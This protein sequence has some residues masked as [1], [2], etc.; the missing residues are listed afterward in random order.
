MTSIEVLLAAGVVVLIAC[1]YGWQ[2]IRQRV[3][4]L[5]KPSMPVDKSRIDKMIARRIVVSVVGRDVY[6]KGPL[7]TVVHVATGDDAPHALKIAKHRVNR[8]AVWLVEKPYK[9][10]ESVL[11]VREHA[12]AYEESTWR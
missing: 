8:T 6:A 11:S 7:R 3:Y 4:A 1:V 9:E 10:Q 2:M 5:T 12:K